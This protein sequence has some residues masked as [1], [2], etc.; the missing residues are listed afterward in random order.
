MIA[1]VRLSAIANLLLKKQNLR[2]VARHHIHHALRF[3]SAEL[4]KSA[5]K[6]VYMRIQN[7][8]MFEA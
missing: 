2:L 5:S 4:P 3:D 8:F 1:G 6:C 7:R